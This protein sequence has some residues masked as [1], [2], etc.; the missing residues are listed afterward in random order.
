MSP[1]AA[2]FVG[3]SSAFSFLVERLAEEPALLLRQR[4]DGSGFR[5]VLSVAAG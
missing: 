4:L 1:A 2:S 5:G 3:N